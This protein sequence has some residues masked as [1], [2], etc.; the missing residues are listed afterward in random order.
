[1]IP[2]HAFQL[3]FGSELVDNADE[4]S[5]RFLPLSDERYANGHSG[6]CETSKDRAPEILRELNRVHMRDVNPP[7]IEEGRASCRL[8]QPVMKNGNR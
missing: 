4:L 7:S 3:V 2:D 1:M 5:V 6:A 8:G